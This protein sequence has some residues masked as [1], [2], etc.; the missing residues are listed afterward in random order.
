MREKNDFFGVKL[1]RKV[2]IEDILNNDE[3]WHRSGEEFDTIINRRNVASRRSLR[4]FEKQRN[5]DFCR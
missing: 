4:G 2:I 3:Y 5:S 1:S